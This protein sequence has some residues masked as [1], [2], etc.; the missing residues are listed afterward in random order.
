MIGK[1]RE[2]QTRKKKGQKTM[3]DRAIERIEYFMDIEPWTEKQLAIQAWILG[4]ALE[5]TD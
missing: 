2:N 4:M 1:K 5:S 3:R